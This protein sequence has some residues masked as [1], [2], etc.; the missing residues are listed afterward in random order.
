MTVLMPAL[1]LAMVPSAAEALPPP[2]I[3]S[4]PPVARGFA[5]VNGQRLYYELHGPEGGTPL[6]LLHGGDPCIETSWAKLLP[7][8]ARTR[9]VIAFDQQGHGRSADVADRPFTFEGSADDT[10]A[11]LRHLGVATAD[12][13][14]FS[15]GASIAMQVAIRHPEVVRRLVLASG[16]AKRDGLRPEFWEG[17]AR[18]RLEDMPPAL[19]R[20]YQE[21][22][23]H[24]AELPSF[25]RKSR[26][27]MLGFRDW[28]DEAL[29]AIT[30][31]ALVVV[32]DADV[33]R[34]EHAVALTQ[35]LP[36]ARLAVLPMTD[37]EA[38]V[39]G[40]SGWL[41]P[42]VEEFLG[43]PRREPPRA[44][45]PSSSPRTSPSR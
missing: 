17:M 3:A 25:F 21:T 36:R 41:L 30:A 14:G 16:M 32:G 4:A 35:L 29:R 34:P 26:D 12:L 13:M 33:V 23:P 5:P 22:S 9:R 2:A 1:A 7:A 37:H 28:P 11:L 45:A 19:A 39:M 24:P 31:P 10:A 43:D 38:V 8:L 20:A 15:N 42:M 44:P 6:V 40:R 18:A 27:R